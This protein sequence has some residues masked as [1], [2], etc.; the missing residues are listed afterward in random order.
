MRGGGRFLNTTDND[1]AAPLGGAFGGGA[2]LLGRSFVLAV[3][4]ALVRRHQQGSAGQ[5]ARHN[6]GRVAAAANAGVVQEV[7]VLVGGAAGQGVS[8]VTTVFAAATGW[9]GQAEKFVA[10]VG[11]KVLPVIISYNISFL[12]DTL[13]KI[14]I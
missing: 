10:R 9:V 7:T 4:A 5:T 13:R 3:A 12:K 2:A 14:R 6:L 11:V 8:P 1:A